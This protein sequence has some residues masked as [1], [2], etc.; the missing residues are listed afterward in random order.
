MVRLQ[1]LQLAANVKIRRLDNRSFLGMSKVLSRLNM[2]GNRV[3]SIGEGAFA[4]LEGLDSLNL[5]DQNT[6]STGGCAE[7]HPE[8][9]R[10]LHKLQSLSLSTNSVERWATPSGGLA[11]LKTLDLGVN[12]LREVGSRWFVRM[13]ALE[14]LD[15]GGNVQLAALAPDAFA[16]LEGLRSLHMKGASPSLPVYNRSYFPPSL[17]VFGAPW[18]GY[19]DYRCVNYSAAGGG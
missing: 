5:A 1:C 6:R 12:H 10:G 13:P 19:P 4:P 16:G 8:A 7:I 17:E 18:A 15:L 9:F 11:A 2:P 14:T 3:R